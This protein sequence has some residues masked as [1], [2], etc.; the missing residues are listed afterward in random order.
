M[1]PNAS[2]TW[3]GS[4]RRGKG[5]VTSGSGTLSQSR[6]LGNCGGEGKETNPYELLAAAHATCF[7]MALAHE[8]A[9]AGF[10]PQRIDTTVTLTMEPL[11]DGWTVAAIQLDVLAEAPRATQGD[12]I[13]AAVSAKTSCTISRLLKTN[14]SMSAKLGKSKNHGSAKVRRA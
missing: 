12:F 1:K 10:T 13:R 3:V 6:Y 8:L 11:S 4:P 14:I 2:A 7:S 9:D 5:V